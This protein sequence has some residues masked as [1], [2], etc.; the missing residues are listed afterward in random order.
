MSGTQEQRQQRLD[1]VLTACPAVI[2]SMKWG[3]EEPTVDWISH[4]IETIT[5]YPIKDIIQPDFWA[6]RIH[7]RDRDVEQRS[8]AA[9]RLQGAMQIE[10][11]VRF[12]DG[13]YHWIQDKMRV[14][15]GDDGEPHRIVGS[16]HDITHEK[17]MQ[18]EL[19]QRDALLANLTKW[20]PGML[21]QLILQPDGKTWFPYASQGIRDVY[22]ISP[23]AAREDARL[24]T[25]HIHP[26][27]L[28]LYEKSMRESAR[29]MSTWSCDYRVFH[30]KRGM[31][32]L[33]GEAEPERLPDGSI[34]WHGHI[35]DATEQKTLENTLKRQRERLHHLAHYDALT[36]LPNRA[37][38]ADRIHMAIEKAR[39]EHQC[40]AVVYFDLDDFKPVNDRFGHET[41]D[42]LLQLVAQRLLQS[43]RSSDT[44]A[45]IGGDEFV[46]LI[47]D[48]QPDG[49]MRCVE[50]IIKFIQQPIQLG[51]ESLILSASI[52]VAQYPNDDHTP[53]ALLRYADLA[54]YQAKALGRN[55]ICHFNDLAQRD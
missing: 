11:R 35:S 37:L 19:Q 52:G 29:C 34:L 39:R 24:A 23:E 27:D 47:A 17:A 26:E 42:K 40:L 51:G 13:H 46:L 8:E 55:Q 43:V 50:E 48:T 22:G 28:P 25:R 1:E 12:A 53:E 45:R 18:M 21:Y 32:W 15:Y 31:R 10:Y 2:Y 54:M 5:G 33:R 9:L 41:G 44:V 30:C 36:G 6:Q 14:L 38:F 4:N 16:W 3:K 20:V 49:Y 7:P